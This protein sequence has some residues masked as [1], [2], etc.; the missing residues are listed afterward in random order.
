[1]IMIRIIVGGRLH[2]SASGV[3][4]HIARSTGQ[5]SQRQVAANKE[6]NAGSK[7]KASNKAQGKPDQ[8]AA[9]DESSNTSLAPVKFARV[10]LIAIVHDSVAS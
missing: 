9:Q 4:S 6:S 10:V 2:T 7:E 8:G 3:S 1:M 5:W